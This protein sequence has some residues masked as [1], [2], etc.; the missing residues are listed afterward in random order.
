MHATAPPSEGE[1][2]KIRANRLYPKAGEPVT[3]QKS[4]NQSDAISPI[5]LLVHYTAGNTLDGAV[6]WFMN[7]DARASSHVVI[8]RDGRIVQMVA[9]NKRAWH[10]GKSTW[11]KLDGMNQ[12]AI[13]IE[14][15]NAGKVRKRPDG[16]W[17][18]WANTVLPDDEVSIATHKGE[19]TAAG[20]H[21]YTQAQ[22]SAA[23]SVASLL[24]ATYHFTDV[25]GHDDVSPGRKTDPGP[26]FPM[27]S[28]RSIVLGR[29]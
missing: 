1:P 4:P 14:L 28:F 2:M 9:F 25:L 29:A 11:G 15:V 19:V 17:V 23:S 12:Y 5:Y 20:W 27:Q 26:L 3:F 18:N 7:P 16:K 21:E 13:G 8:G 6:S 22:I 24:N 10:A